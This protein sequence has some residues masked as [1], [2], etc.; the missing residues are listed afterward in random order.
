MKTYNQLIT[1]LNKVEALMKA[2][3]LAAKTIRRI[4]PGESYKMLGG[5]KVTGD[6]QKVKVPFRNIIR[7][8]DSYISNIITPRRK[9]ENFQ[10]AIGGQ[11]YNTNPFKGTELDTAIRQKKFRGQGKK[12]SA[13]LDKMFK[14]MPQRPK[15]QPTVSRGLTPSLGDSNRMLDVPATKKASM[16]MNPKLDWQRTLE[17]GR[18]GYRIPATPVYNKNTRGQLTTKSVKYKKVPDSIENKIRDAIRQRRKK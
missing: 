18:P 10:K 6:L 12:Q 14:G 1:E 9:I 4:S 8:R 7:H 5:V 3:K 13:E 15:N 11:N 17:K 2:G 16:E